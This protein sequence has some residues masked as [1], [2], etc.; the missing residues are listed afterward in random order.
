MKKYKYK[1]EHFN[2]QEEY[3]H[4]R[5]NR[6]RWQKKWLEKFEKANPEH[7]ERRLIRQRLY[8]KYYHSDSR[9]SFTEWLKKN[10]GITDIK[11]IPLD[12]LRGKVSKS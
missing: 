9:E 1:R 10:Y 11:T 12:N 2:S 4:F 3:D 8:S 6:T 5:Q 7:K